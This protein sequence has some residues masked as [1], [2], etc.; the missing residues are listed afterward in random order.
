MT[1]ETEQARVEELNERI[2]L[3]TTILTNLEK[4][5]RSR[6]I[7][8][9]NSY[10]DWDNP[11]FKAHPGWSS[12]FANDQLAHRAHNATRGTAQNELRDEAV[13]ALTACIMSGGV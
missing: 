4:K 9:P 11:I 12:E 8:M 3:M 5:W 6:G 7:N 1:C 10:G 2:A 13:P